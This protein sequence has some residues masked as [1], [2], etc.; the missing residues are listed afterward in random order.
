LVERALCGRLHDDCL[1][2]EM[3]LK[4]IISHSVTLDKLNTFKENGTSFEFLSVG[5]LIINMIRGIILNIEAYLCYHELR[6]RYRS[7]FCAIE[8]YTWKK[9]FEI[10][11]VDIYITNQDG[12]YVLH[13]PNS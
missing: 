2:Y 4:L 13:S 7:I 5:K 6:K 11:S 10:F 1:A 9:Q 3:L 8:I 12:S